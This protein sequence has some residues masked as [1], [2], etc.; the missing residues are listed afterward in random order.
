MF[1]RFQ[2]VSQRRAKNRAESGLV[3]ATK[4]VPVA[5]FRG[6]GKV[7]VRPPEHYS[8]LGKDRFGKEKERGQL[9]QG[10]SH[11]RDR[12][13]SGVLRFAV[14]DGVFVFEENEME[15]FRVRDLQHI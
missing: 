9:Q 12:L 1:E 6:V 3:L 5:E 14:T 8:D 13:M 11:S 7:N 15:L 2:G 10:H 4:N